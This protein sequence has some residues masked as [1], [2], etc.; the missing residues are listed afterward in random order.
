MESSDFHLSL[1]KGFPNSPI[2]NRIDYQLTDSE[3][4]VLPV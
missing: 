2:A 1:L 4:V 3:T